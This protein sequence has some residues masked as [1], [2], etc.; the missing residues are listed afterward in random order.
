MAT[1]TPHIT[2]GLAMSAGTAPAPVSDERETGALDPT[3]AGTVPALAILDHR[4]RRRTLPAATALPGHYLGLEDDDG[5]LNLLPIDAKVVHIGRASNSDL[6]LE[7]IQIS[8]R[9]A[10]LVRYGHHVR[11]LDD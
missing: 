10:I 7:H 1:E 9:H 2:A 3:L 6:R 4:S 11:M 8:R 5:E